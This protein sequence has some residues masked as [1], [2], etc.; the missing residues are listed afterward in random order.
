MQSLTVLSIEQQK[1]NVC[2]Y[3]F[4]SILFL[5][6]FFFGGWTFGSVRIFC[7]SYLF[8]LISILYLHTIHVM[9]SF[10]FKIK[11]GCCQFVRNFNTV[12]QIDQICEFSNFIQTKNDHEIYFFS[13]KQTNNIHSLCCKSY[14]CTFQNLRTFP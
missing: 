5:F 12:F 10:C 13:L 7:F 2:G 8:F 6:F 1:E 9:V 11:I 4:N 3:K 14:H